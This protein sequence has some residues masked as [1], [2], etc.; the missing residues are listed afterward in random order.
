MML[1]WET[2]YKSGSRN[3]ILSSSEKYRLEYQNEIQLVKKQANACHKG[4]ITW[5]GGSHKFNRRQKPQDNN[6]QQMA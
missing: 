5:A 6:G 1:N 4:R 3:V 2:L